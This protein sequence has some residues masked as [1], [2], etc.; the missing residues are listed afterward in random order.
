MNCVH[1]QLVF[2]RYSCAKQKK[3]FE[4]FYYFIEYVFFTLQILYIF[5]FFLCYHFGEVTY[6]LS[7]TSDFIFRFLFM[8]FFIEVTCYSDEQSYIV[9]RGLVLRGQT[10]RAQGQ[11]PGPFNRLQNLY[12]VI[13]VQYI[14]SL[15][16]P[17]STGMMAYG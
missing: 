16:L 11:R 9:E 10:Y 4:G 1:F 2:M 12:A 8:Y 17:T 15:N 6:F 7:V 5:L 13:L 14:W 3:Y